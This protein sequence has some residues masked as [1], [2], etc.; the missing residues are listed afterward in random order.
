[1]IRLS[2]LY[3]VAQP[4]KMSEVGSL[5]VDIRIP[6]LVLEYVHWP[7]RVTVLYDRSTDVNEDAPTAWENFHICSVFSALIA[8][9]YWIHTPL[10]PTF[11]LNGRGT[12]NRLKEHTPGPNPHLQK[13]TLSSFGKSNYRYVLTNASE[14][15]VGEFGLWGIQ[16]A[17]RR[18]WLKCK[19]WYWLVIPFWTYQ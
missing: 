5:M 9:K 8:H 1:M 16:T 11:F 13:W 14:L 15:G 4:Q 12:K 6:T 7:W 10:Q 17:V 3:T 2:L 18:K 19:D